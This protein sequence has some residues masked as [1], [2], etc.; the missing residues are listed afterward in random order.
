MDI[1]VTSALRA[2]YRVT[3]VA[4][5]FNATFLSSDKNVNELV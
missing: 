5:A 3:A 1:R 2:I 4:A